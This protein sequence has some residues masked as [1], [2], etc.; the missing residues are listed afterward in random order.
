MKIVFLGT[1]GAVPSK[2]RG[3][4]A[5]AIHAKEWLLF[6]CGEGT[7]RQMMTYGIPYGSIKAIFLSHSHLDHTLGIYGLL[8]TFELSLP[9]IKLPVFLPEGMTLKNKNVVQTQI[10]E[11]KLYENNEFEIYAF[12]VKHSENSHGFII[13]EKDRVKFNEQKAH[14]LGIKGKMFKEI[15]EKG[16]LK[17]GK[18]K[19]KLKEVTWIKKG[20]KI[21]YSGDTVYCKELIKA[22]KDADIL[23]HEST[24]F[25]EQEKEAKEF[26]HSSLQDAV[27]VAEKAKVKKLIL[28]HISPRYAKEDELLEQAIKQFNN[29]II[30]K[31]GLVIDL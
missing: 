15:E 29:S 23:I 6:D 27:K 13:K 5:I 11:G 20:R 21:V 31:D 16:F 25:G 7:Q 4:P 17:I 10:K 3:M 1:S 12:K 9:H 14:S 26:M 28:T 22:S 24:F 30:A 19:I 8:K 2:E 18:N